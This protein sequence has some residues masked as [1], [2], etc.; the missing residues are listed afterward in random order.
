MIKCVNPNPKYW[1]T[2]V[3]GKYLDFSPENV[4]L[5]FNLPMMEENARPYTRR[6]IGRAHV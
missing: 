4:R 3:Q 1:L 2:M 6:E 5:A